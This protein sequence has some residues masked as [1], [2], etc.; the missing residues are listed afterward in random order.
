MPE[1]VNSGQQTQVATP[2]SGQPGATDVN[3]EERYKGA[4]SKINE[5]M[6]E[7]NSLKEQL[8]ARASELEQL[9]SE[10]SL[11]TE[12]GKIATATRD[13]KLNVI[14]AEKQTLE[15]E[16]A[17]LRALKLKVDTAKKL[18]KPELLMVVDLVPNVTEPAAME[19]TMQ[20]FAAYGEAM[21]KQR[22]TQLLSG[23]TPMAGGQTSALPSTPASQ[24]AWL[25]KINELPLGSTERRSAMDDYGKWLQETFNK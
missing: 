23:V 9:R 1:D 22:E 25:K 8:L 17:T 4:S 14:L 7:I 5:L 19:Y 11:K 6:R 10:L 13:D 18:G 12:E 3:W 2:T 15:Q 16:L 21:A 24:E 20:Q